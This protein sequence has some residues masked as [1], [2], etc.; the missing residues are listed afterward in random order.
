MA[1]FSGS[2]PH[3]LLDL[4]DWR[5]QGPVKE[6]GELGK[7]GDGKAVS[8]PSNEADTSKMETFRDE[9]WF[10]L[11]TDGEGAPYVR[12]RAP[13]AGATTSTGS[14]ATTRSELREMH[15]P[16]R[17]RKSSWDATGSTVHN[18]KVRLA[19]TRVMEKDGKRSRVAIAQVHK[20]S[21]D[22]ILVYLDGKSGQLRWKQDSAVQD[23]SLGS[24]SLGDYVNIGL[25]VRDGRC[26]IH[27]N[28][29]KKAEGELTGDAATTCYFKTGCY[30]Q[31]NNGSDGYP[32]NAFNEVRIAAVKVQHDVPWAPGGYDPIGPGVRATRGGEPQ[33]PEQPEGPQVGAQPDT[34][35]PRRLR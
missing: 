11:V 10:V 34:R 12:L 32:A 6:N 2:S 14:S 5:W 21:A 19:V 22:G 7:E 28:D 1:A 23:G 3:D 17:D 8:V 27:V 30:N 9:P 20:T 16:A 24:Y 31:D 15:F 25:S 29:V 26:T 33:Q 13:G 35:K 18:L 4:N